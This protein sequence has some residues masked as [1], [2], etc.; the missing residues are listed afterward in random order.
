M[1]TNFKLSLLILIVIL[2]SVPCY[3]KDVSISLSGGLGYDRGVWESGGQPSPTGKMTQSSMTWGAAIQIL[4]DKWEWQPTL[5]ISYRHSEFDFSNWQA[6]IQ[7]AK[8]DVFSAR[9]GLTKEL[10][11]ASIYGL[12]G[13]TTIYHNA[14]LF[15][16]VPP[17]DHGSHDCRHTLFSMKFGAY[18]LWNVGFFKLGPELSVEIFP[19]R[20]GF[21]RCRNFHTNHLV[22]CLWLRGQW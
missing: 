13:I 9:I 15:E 12:F 10:N 1:T 16:T 2:I 22:P 5:E 7:E 8:P 17:L 6:H 3:G 11:F 4:Y 14:R 21:E 19:E 18:K 20:P